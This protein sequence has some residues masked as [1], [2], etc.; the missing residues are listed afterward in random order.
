MK[1]RGHA[2]S[3]EEVR[4]P[5]VHAAEEWFDQPIYHLAAEP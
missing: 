2:R 5:G 4:R 3:A 1:L